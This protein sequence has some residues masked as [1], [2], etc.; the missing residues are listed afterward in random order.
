MK[1]RPLIIALVPLSVIGSWFLLDY[2]LARALGGLMILL[3]NALLHE[4]FADACLMRPLFSVI[5][6]VWG[7]I[8]MFLVATPWWLRIAYERLEKKPVLRKSVLGVAVFSV[9]VLIFL[10]LF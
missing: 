6:I 9:V 1:F 5:C 4:A 10:P 7:V 3:S 8:G 2:H